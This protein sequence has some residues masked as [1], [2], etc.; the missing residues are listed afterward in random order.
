MGGV[1]NVYFCLATHS[2]LLPQE[3][4]TRACLPSLVLATGYPSLGVSKSERICVVEVEVKVGGQPPPS[5]KLGGH[6]AKLSTGRD[7]PR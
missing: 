2:Q 1:S 5:S 6:Q 4:S 7:L 3:P